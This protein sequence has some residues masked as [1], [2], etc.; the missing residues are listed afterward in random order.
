MIATGSQD[1]AIIVSQWDSNE[2]IASFKHDSVV[3]SIAFSPDNTK[4]ASGSE[5]C[6]VRVWD[7]TAN[8]SLL[9]MGPF[10]STRKDWGDRTDSVS[11][12]RDGTRLLFACQAAIRILDLQTEAVIHTI[13]YESRIIKAVFNLDETRIVSCSLAQVTL[14]VWNIESSNLELTVELGESPAC[15]F[16]R[17]N[18]TDIYVFCP[19]DSS[20]GVWSLETKCT[21]VYVLKAHGNTWKDQVN[22][23]CLTFDDLRIVTCT[24][25]GVFVWNTAT[26][27]LLSMDNFISKCVATTSS[28]QDR[29]RITGC[30]M[31]G[32]FVHVWDME[33]NSGNETP[34][35]NVTPLCLKFKHPGSGVNAICCS[36]QDVILI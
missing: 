10:N 4:L 9:Q 34:P 18:V 24:G 15:S 12:S 16:V 5:D 30:S 6:T 28:P 36:A 11:F 32:G 8:T 13:L 20:L 1:G 23:M 33:L 35:A 2:P 14:D 29:Y 19:G 7:V 17:G 26:L 25:A 21:M 31:T 27:T 3:Y 22:D